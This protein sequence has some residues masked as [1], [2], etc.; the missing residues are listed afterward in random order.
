M[1][2]SSNVENFD[3]N[4]VGDSNRSNQMTDQMTAVSETKSSNA[5][6]P[7]SAAKV[8]KKTTNA[9][10]RC[11]YFVRGKTCARGDSC[12]FL[13]SW[14]E[15]AIPDASIDKIGGKIEK[16]P[17]LNR[18][19]ND[20]VLDNMEC[21]VVSKHIIFPENVMSNKVVAKKEL[22]KDHRKAIIDGAIAIALNDSDRKVG[23]KRTKKIAA[24]DRKKDVVAE[25][26]LNINPSLIHE[27]VKTVVEP[28]AKV[29][30]GSVS[31]KDT[32]KDV[33]VSKEKSF[34]APKLSKTKKDKGSGNVKN[35]MNS[36]NN[37]SHSGERVEEVSVNSVP[38]VQGY[39]GEAI[40][41]PVQDKGEWPAASQV[42]EVDNSSFM[43][44]LIQASEAERENIDEGLS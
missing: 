34:V 30:S 7:N 36:C 4:L 23:E 41:G 38:S 12:P 39:S 18:S 16:K 26:K 42:L 11:H 27:A 44:S 29:S 8:K 28:T 40:L 19:K 13:H 33:V 15:S 35:S 24:D 9:D 6:K 10:M 17:Q 3:V 22:E 2:S 25:S 20:A 1:Q 37:S 32:I 14:E 43:Q 5:T 31:G 21:G